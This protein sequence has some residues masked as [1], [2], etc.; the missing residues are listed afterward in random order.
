M[1]ETSGPALYARF[2]RGLALSPDKAAVRLA[3]E[4]ITYSQAHELAL[5]WAG[6]LLAA[7]KPPTI[8][9]VL[10][11]KGV[12]SYVGI[13]AGLYTGATVVPLHPDF[14]VVRTRRMLELSGVSA[15]IVDDLGYAAL[16]EIFG[17]ELDIPVLAPRRAPGADDLIRSIPVDPARALI[18]P[19]PVQSTDTAY[20]L[21]TSGSTGR[22]K[23]VPITHGNTSHY[24][25]LLDERYDFT[26]DDVFSQ[27]F[28]LNFDCAMFDLFCAWGAGASISY[29]PPAAYRDLPEFVASQGITVWFSTPSAI[30]LIRKMGGLT[31]DSMPSLRWSFFAGEAL[32]MSDTADWQAAASASTVENLYGPTEL[33]VTVTGHRWEPATS[34]SQ[35]INGLVPIGEIHEGHEFLL[36]TEDGGLSEV[37]GELC[38]TGPQMTAGYLDPEDNI[39]RFLERD[40]KTWYRTGDRVRSLDG[41]VLVYLGRLDAQVQVQ[42]WRV[43]LAEIEHALRECAGVD[44]AVTVTR[45]VDGNTELVVFYTGAVTSPVELGRQ[46]RKILP[47]GMLPRHYEHVAEFPLN[48]N[49][50]VDRPTLASQASE[51][52]VAAGGKG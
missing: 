11:G 7:E 41:G 25:G 2:L 47:V 8:I 35:G 27:T 23:G 16:P 45:S 43:E 29:V 38:I 40:G 12:E 44:D 31:P 24:F 32:R 48:S 15:L 18:S 1:T 3:T 46:L 21:F 52:L 30:S 37:E 39:G 5:L 4:T 36:V 13:L 50:K 9:G 20:M 19:R 17:T 22:P 28:D 34:P 26:A 33:T 49:R 42:G 6:S 51:L 10:A 14:P